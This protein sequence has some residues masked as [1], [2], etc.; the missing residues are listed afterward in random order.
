MD[1]YLIE[2]VKKTKSD[3]SQWYPV[4]A[5]G[6]MGTL[7]HRELNLNTIKSCFTVRVV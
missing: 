2:G 3:S 7:K 1:K 6:A 5:L 4:K